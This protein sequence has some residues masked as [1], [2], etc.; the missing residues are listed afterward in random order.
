MK[1][2]F[3]VRLGLDE[4]ISSISEDPKNPASNARSRCLDH[5]LPLVAKFLQFPLNGL[6]RGIRC[7][8]QGRPRFLRCQHFARKREKDAHLVG[9]LL[10]MGIFIKRHARMNDVLVLCVQRF[11]RLRDPLAQL[12]LDVSM[13]SLNLNLHSDSLKMTSQGS[14]A[15]MRR[16][17][18]V[19]GYRF[20]ESIMP[21][22]LCHHCLAEFY[23]HDRVVANDTLWRDLLAI[24]GGVAVLTAPAA[25]LKVAAHDQFMN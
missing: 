9:T 22:H 6:K 7:I 25:P 10:M 12:G 3:L 16:E 8:V 11:Q 13:M 4:S 1:V 17:V 24:P 15:V 21:Q 19:R 20:N 5:P 14:N 23:G 2:D 18:G